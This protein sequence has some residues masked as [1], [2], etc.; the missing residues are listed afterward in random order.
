M[1]S[2]LIVLSIP[3]FFAFM[4]ARDAGS[5][6]AAACRSTASPTRSA[7]SATASASRSSAPSPSPSP[8][9]STSAVFAHARLTT[10][11]PHSIARLDRPL[12][13]R[14]LPLLRL[15]PRLAPRELPVGRPRRAPP[16]RGVQLL[17]GA[18]AELVRPAAH[19]VALLSCRSRSPAFRR[20]CSSSRSRSTRST[21]SSSTRAWSRTLGPLEW[22]INTPSHHRV[23]HG[24]NPRYV[25]RNYAGIFIIWDELLGTFEPEADE[26]VYGLVKPL[27]SFSP[28]W[29][30]LHRWVEIAA[31]SRRTRRLRDKLLRLAGAARV[32]P[33][34]SRRPRRRARARSRRPV[35]RR[36]ARTARRDLR[37]A[38]AFV[39]VL[40]RRLVVHLR[41]GATTRTS[42][43]R[44]RRRRRAARGDR[45]LRLDLLAAR[46]RDDRVGAAQVA[47]IVVGAQ[48]Q[49]SASP[50]RSPARPSA[51]AP[52]LG[53]RVDAQRRRHRQVHALR[54]A[55]HRDGELDVARRARRRRQPVALVADEERRRRQ[56]V[57]RLERRRR[58]GH[59]RVE[60]EAARLQIRGGS[61]RWSRRAR[62]RATCRSPASRA[63]R[64]RTTSR[65]RASRARRWPRTSAAPRR[66]CADRA[67]SRARRPAR[68]G[69]TRRRGRSSRGARRR[70]A[71]RARR[72]PAASFMAS[73]P[74]PLR[75][76]VP[77]L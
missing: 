46:A 67:G 70:G 1:E 32:A 59:R 9:A 37:V 35:A 69:A 65:R 29:A 53:V 36:R 72:S 5:R 76:A 16:V 19:R 68:R 11:P 31:M 18:A 45:Q 43:R 10:L 74:L 6:T 75:T 54:E 14:R 17:G 44:H 15:S 4:G 20:R 66:R 27:G 58:A 3:V 34:R 41:R 62:C 22:I 12:L 21:S 52:P 13:R 47:P 55:A 77:S 51:R 50:S 7:T 40:A 8:S 24:V 63:R 39:L 38:G 33:R 64:S 28:L 56:R 48:A 25:D 30:N 26:P 71:A 23:H 61:A 49:S 60:A 2:I 73:T 42:P 57:E